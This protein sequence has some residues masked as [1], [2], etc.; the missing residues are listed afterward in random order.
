MVRWIMLAMLLIAPA[1]AAE[2]TV[3]NDHAA[4]PEGPAII[5]GR[6]HYVEYG[7]HKLMSWDGA[8]NTELWR[9]EG[10]GPSAVAPFGAD[11]V[12][13]CYD[14][15]QIVQVTKDGRTLQSFSQDAAG[16]SFVGPNDFAS[17]GKGGVYFTT[18]GPW[19]PGPIVGKIFHLSAA[20]AIREVA[21]D[22]HYANGLALSPDGALL[23]CNESEAGR[24][25]TF[26]VAADGSLGDRRLFVRVFQIDPASGAEAY[27]D[28]LKVAPDGR[29]WIGQYSKSR[30]V[31]A[32][33][34]GGFVRAIDLPS[35]A[36]PNLA[37]APDGRSLFVMAVD[38]RANPPYW[39]KVYQVP[40][41]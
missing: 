23:Y 12:I 30:L 33:A 24:V 35:A 25:I 38:D 2:I 7:A 4:F 14:S 40:L 1:R 36:A 11:L 29:L 9:Q 37:F 18:S 27:P 34:K 41:D 15:N 10:C 26:A 32:D 19:E 17:D 39:G 13:T 22:L 16:Q 5:D 3:I 28:G 6:L 21:N 20:G 8:S 31:V